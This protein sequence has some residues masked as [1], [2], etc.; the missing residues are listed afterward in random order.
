MKAIIA[1]IVALLAVGAS[2]Y[3]IL[4]REHFLPGPVACTAEAKLC[5]DGSSVGRTGP[6][7]E[8]APCPGEATSTAQGVGLGGHCGGFIQ[9]A[10]TCAAGLRCQLN[11]SSP[12]T[13]GVCVADEGTSTGPGQG[14]LP[15]KS[16]IQG[17]VMTGPTCPVEK[18]PPEPQCADKPYQTLVAIF[19]ASDPVH[20]FA[21]VKS[22]A[23]GYFKVSLPPG[24]YT[25]GAGESNLPRCAQVSVS[26]GPDS[27]AS[28]TISCDT[29]IR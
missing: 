15:Y 29:G 20:A 23:S 9:N 24:D 3:L 25:V 18:N 5:P 2:A 1:G 13:G 10:P 27:Y 11:V 16:G 14:I 26:V 4:E 7:C 19:R 8:F 12:D 28:T 21:L 22:S 6:N 17:M